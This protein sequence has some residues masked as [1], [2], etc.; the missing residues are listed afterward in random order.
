MYLKEGRWWEGDLL[1][2]PHCAALPTPI[3]ARLKEKCSIGSAV[4]NINDHLAFYPDK[5]D[6][7]E[8]IPPAP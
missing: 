1:A 3:I 5:M 7:I 8:K 4:A 2:D 6:A